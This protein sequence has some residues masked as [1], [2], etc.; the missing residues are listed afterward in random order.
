MANFLRIFNK[1]LIFK[2]NELKSKKE[3]S[4]TARFDN[5]IDYQNLKTISIKFKWDFKKKLLFGKDFEYLQ[6][7]IPKNS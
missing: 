5:R 1:Y 3:C 4:E 7:L 2:T 6:P